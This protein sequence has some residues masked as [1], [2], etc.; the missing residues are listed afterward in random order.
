MQSLVNSIVQNQTLTALSILSGLIALIV[1]GYQLMK[2]A[3]ALF[4]GRMDRV[5]E[6]NITDARKGI[7]NAPYLVAVL[8]NHAIILAVF[9]WFYSIVKNLRAEVLAS[10]TQSEA[11]NLLSIILVVLMSVLSLLIGDRG[12]DIWLISRRVIRET[13]ERD[14]E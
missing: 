1:F 4:Q 3:H 11:V 5:T 9:V 2:R 8:F 14:G 6:R 12:A 10:S 7:D 13:K